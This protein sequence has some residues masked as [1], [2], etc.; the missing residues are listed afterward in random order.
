MRRGAVRGTVLTLLLCLAPAGLCALEWVM[1]PPAQLPVPK[2]YHAAGV[3]EGRILVAGGGHIGSFSFASS[4]T[5]YRYDPAADAWTEMFCALPEKRG[6]P[7]SVAVRV[8]DPPGSGTFEDR[9]FVFGGTDFGQ[10]PFQEGVQT[11]LAWDPDASC[12]GGGGGAGGWLTMQANFPRSMAL[13]SQAVEV[14]G[15]VY[16]VGGHDAEAFI[17]T[18][19]ILVYDPAADLL[20]G[21]SGELLPRPRTEGSAVAVGRKI[22]YFGGYRTDYGVPTSTSLALDLDAGTW[23]PIASMPYPAA[24]TAAIADGDTIYVLGGWNGSDQ[25]HAEV[26]A[27]DVASDTWS[28]DGALGCRDAT[29]FP[30]VYEGRAGLTVH[31]ADDGS[32]DRL[33][34]VGGATGTSEELSC[35]ESSPIAVTQ[36]TT[37]PDFAGLLAA[38]EPE[39]PDPPRVE[40][41]WNPADETDSPPVTYNLHR[42]RDPAFLPDASN[43]VAQGV[44][45]TEWTDTGV[46]C[47]ADDPR[48]YYYLVRARDSASPPNED[49]NTERLEVS[50]LCDPPPAPPDLGPA[51]RV[52]KTPDQ[53][54][55]LD[56]SR[57]AAPASVVGY[58]VYRRIDDPRDLYG[59]SPYLEPAI[60]FAE[61][62]DAAGRLLYYKVRALRDCLGIESAD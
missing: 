19:E 29:G 22:Y 15:L 52:G 21:Y 43:V 49:P 59:S 30:P 39:C 44:V 7:A 57:Y 56:W 47:W 16:L 31:R 40:L 6:A 54:P 50:V 25:G 60:D 10:W 24:G 45:A 58:R 55:R 46:L 12:G 3:V 26:L 5:V 41:S 53:V 9:L 11:I 38:F 4:D 17:P 14:D 20:A 48:P 27:Y 36:D 37:P 61:D 8:E 28:L 34:A 51:L 33:Y 32:E 23:S 42:S 18:D 62:P 1:N 2:G 13:S 35:H